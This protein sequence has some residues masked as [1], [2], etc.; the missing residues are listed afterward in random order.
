MQLTAEPPT[1]PVAAPTSIPPI[2]QPS[3]PVAA[4]PDVIPADS[5][6]ANEL[7]ASPPGPTQVIST[8]APAAGTLMSHVDYLS[9]LTRPEIVQKYVADKRAGIATSSKDYEDAYAKRLVGGVFGD[10]KTVSADTPEGPGVLKS[11]FDA[12]TNMLAGGAKQINSLYGVFLHADVLGGKPFRPRMM[13][14][15]EWDQNAA[16]LKI[17]TES[18]MLNGITAIRQFAVN[19]ANKFTRTTGNADDLAA[20]KDQFH[21]DVD[22][23]EAK[24]RVAKGESVFERPGAFGPL[25]EPEAPAHPDIKTAEMISQSPLADPTILVPGIVAS[26]V[27]KAAG[28]LDRAQTIVEAGAE[29]TRASL[30]ARSLART[31]ETVSSGVKAATSVIDNTPRVIRA[32]ATMAAT[33]GL[34]GDAAVTTVLGLLAGSE[35]GAT[36]AGTLAKASTTLDE[37]AASLRASAPGPVSKFAAAAYAQLTPE[38]KQLAL[39]QAYNLPFALGAETHEDMVHGIETGL[40]AHGLFSIP[41]RVNN[42]SPIRDMWHEASRSP[43]ERAPIKDYGIDPDLDTMHRDVVGIANNEGSNLVQA[44]RNLLSRMGSKGELYLGRPEDIVKNLMGMAS[45]GYTFFSPETG[46]PIVM[47]PAEAA[48]WAD[49][50]GVSFQVEMPPETPAAGQLPAP[51]VRRSVALVPF[52]ERAPAA[53]VGHE[54]WHVVENTVLSPEERAHFEAETLRVYG[55]TGVENARRHYAQLLGIDPRELSDSRVASEL[56]GETFSGRLNSIPV[57]AFGPGGEMTFKNPGYRKYVRNAAAMVE[58]VLRNLGAEVPETAVPVKKLDAQGR[59]YTTMIPGGKGVRSGLGWELSSELGSLVDNFL[60]SK[61]LDTS[62]AEAQGHEDPFTELHSGPTKENPIQNVR[63]VAP[64]P[65]F[66]KGDPIDEV[67]STDGTVIATDAIVTKVF[68]DPKGEHHYEIEFTDP[69]DGKRKVGMVPEKF[70]QSTIREGAGPIGEP[71]KAQRGIESV[72]KPTPKPAAPVPNARG[73]TAEERA[74]FGTPPAKATPEVLEHNKAVVQGEVAKPAGEQRLLQT[75]YYSASEGSA[76]DTGPIREER[77]KL[78]EASDPKLA[79][80]LR[81]TYDKLIHIYKYEPN[82]KNNR[83]FVTAFSF[84]NFIANAK[85]LDGWLR[86]N[87]LANDPAIKLMKSPQFVEDVQNYW[88]N[89]ANGYRGDG[90]RLVRPSDL[91][92]GT[93]PA[94]NPDYTP[95]KVSKHALEVINL[96]MGIELPRDSSVASR[97]AAKMARENGLAPTLNERGVEITNPLTADLVAKGFEP[98]L[99]HSTVQQLSL[100]KL[101]SKL[102]PSEL[103]GTSRAVLATTRAGFMPKAEGNLTTREVADKYLRSIGNKQEQ[104]EGLAPVNTDLAKRIADFYQEAESHPE[105]PAVRSAYKALADETMAQYRAMAR[106]GIQIEPYTGKGEP[107]ANSAAMRKDVAENKHLFFYKTEGAFEGGADNALLQPSG[108]KVG[109]HE[110]LVNDVFRAVHDYFGHT[111][112]GYEFG[113]RGELNAYLA[114]SKM[115]SDEAKPALAAE[116]LAQ[117]SWVNF[118]RHLRREDGTLPQQG[119]ADYIPLAKRPFAEQKN[120]VVPQHFIDAAEGRVEI[121]PI[122]RASGLLG[123]LPTPKTKAPAEDNPAYAVKPLAEPAPSPRENRQAIYMPRAQHGGETLEHSVGEEPLNLIH[124]GTGGVKELDPVHFGRS[125]I[126]PRSELAGAPRSYFYEQGKHNAN[127][128]VTGRNAVYGAKVSG[129]RIYDGDADKLGYADIVNREKADQMLQDAGYVGISRTAGS[130]KKAY[131]QVELFEPT[132]VQPIHG[133]GAQ[134]MPKAPDTPEF[135]KFFGKSK[136]VDAEG[137]PLVVFHGTNENFTKFGRPGDE[138]GHY[139]TEN[140]TYA[141]EF[142]DR[143]AAFPSFES[144]LNG[145][146]ATVERRGQNVMPVFLRMENPVDLSVA[147]TQPVSLSEIMRK[148]GGQGN[149]LGARGQGERPVWKWLRDFPEILQTYA[150]EA[151]HDGFELRETS[152]NTE[153]NAGRVFYVFD[154]KQIKSA[155]GNRGTFDRRLADIRFMPKQAVPGERE[156]QDVRDTR[157]YRDIARSLTPEEADS[158]RADTAQRMVDLFKDLPS[159]SEFEA[160]AHAGM[161]KKGWYQ[162]AS[163]TLSTVFGPDKER[164]VG[165]LAATSPRQS[166]QENLQMALNIWADWQDA[167]RPLDTETLTPLIQKHAEL[168]ARVPN[169]VKALQGY[170]PELSGNKVEAFR[171]NLLGD[172]SV[173]T[174]DTWMALFGNL[175]Q[176]AFRTSSG[177]LA[178]TAKIRKVATKLDLKPAEV[179]ETVWSFFKTLVEGTTVKRSAKETLRSLSDSDILNTPE[180]HDEVVSNPKVR[181]QLE[182]LGFTGFDQLGDQTNSQGS[183]RLGSLASVAE[184]EGGAGRLRVL[185]RIAGRAQRLSEAQRPGAALAEV[186]GEDPF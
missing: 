109:D 73:V 2:F 99:L 35:K 137:K 130:G 41:E 185:D 145:G 84:D 163:D 63:E 127:D 65:A 47:T 146:V 87:G 52:S 69:A 116:T 82:P 178:F 80:T 27:A 22:L 64:E 180:F 117:N 125:G 149:P 174:N 135:Q 74:R 169:S 44:A 33:H 9:T 131:R 21:F 49:Q 164:F 162:R 128:P 54:L 171:K 85:I 114:H 6:A 182:R 175:D 179:Q 184:Q 97:F 177:H 148:I 101:S 104:H 56:M 31:V 75:N 62:V 79:A 150:H 76:N 141:S 14:E 24:E 183:G 103:K 45:R 48:H 186:P 88:R 93:V 51:P 28:T 34:G 112:G 71:T 156:L 15:K 18:A 39:S 147:G 37:A 5:A 121:S 67:K 155:T 16:E 43:A 40:V 78:V 11:V 81:A 57:G 26:K 181:A 118:G 10:S 126:T 119:D 111:A 138:L 72:V 3:A 134:F 106:A 167:G 89:Q 53:S 60:E 161:A 17:G 86:Q 42:L 102:E 92:E 122:K 50:A 98:N 29:A 120:L 168:H 23:H 36:L 110:L 91:K 124:F 136:V 123:E 68:A 115:F 153:A 133:P 7:S 61:R 142:S 143:A 55:P 4:S 94:E 176:K 19:L 140:P 105:D 144:L 70:L 139:F 46:K 12:G 58:K 59:E 38:A 170:E 157:A 166:V 165:L 83:P 132:T 8:D 173:S 152:D 129:S 154:K 113:P 32:G 25:S 13:S 66:K 30:A 160:A 108:V 107:Y 20:F 159:D 151:G 100:D 158:I 172:M 90:E 1:A 96:L 95:E 77:R